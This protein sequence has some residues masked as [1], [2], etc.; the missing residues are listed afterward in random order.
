MKPIT[1]DYDEKC[2]K[3]GQDG[4]LPNGLCLTCNG[5]LLIEFYKEKL[6][7]GDRPCPKQP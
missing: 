2:A 6:K 5:K 3:C 1:I 4:I 7:K